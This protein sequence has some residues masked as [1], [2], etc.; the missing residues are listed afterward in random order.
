METCD[1]AELKKKYNEF[2]DEAKYALKQ[3]KRLGD[4][5]G[6]VDFR[7]NAIKLF[8]FYVE[9]Y[10]NAYKE[11]IDMII[12]GNISAKEE[13]RINEIVQEVS[14]KETKLD[15][16]FQ[17]AQQKFATEND[18]QIIENDIQKEIDNL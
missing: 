11:L 17:D 5:N 1:D 7:D 16:A 9:V 18:M 4:F 14:E 12:K 6:N 3:I 15:K 8:E 10:E 13:T 2:G